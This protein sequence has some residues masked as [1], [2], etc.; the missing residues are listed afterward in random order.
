MALA[1]KGETREVLPVTRGGTRCSRGM[2]CPADRKAAR[3]SAGTLLTHALLCLPL[4]TR[5]SSQPTSIRPLARLDFLP[6]QS[7]PHIPTPPAPQPRPPRAPRAPRPHPLGL[8]RVKVLL[9][10]FAGTP[11]TSMYACGVTTAGL[12]NLRKKKPP[13]REQMDASDASGYFRWVGSAPLEK[14]R[15]R[16]RSDAGFL[17]LRTRSPLQAS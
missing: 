16:K 11:S 9:G 17:G 13:M 1:S 2:L 6:A 12:M 7:F 14:S 8:T 3:E 4:E 10:C 15:S 5:H